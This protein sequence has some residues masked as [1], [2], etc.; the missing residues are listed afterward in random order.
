MDWRYA[1]LRTKVGKLDGS[2]IFPLLLALVVFHYVTI[3][4]L[5]L[6]AGLSLYM[7]FR[8]RS[9]KWLWRRLRF[10][11][12]RG[13]ILARTPRYWRYVRTGKY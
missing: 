3:L 6:Y 7:S 8:G 1:G 5:V 2:V 9:M 11:L 13:V 10:W 12:R 4:F